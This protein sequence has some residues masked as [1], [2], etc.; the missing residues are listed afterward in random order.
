M[1]RKR[2]TK[3]E[4]AQPLQLPQNK[5]DQVKTRPRGANNISTMS[6]SDLIT[7]QEAAVILNRSVSAFSWANKDGRLEYADHNNRLLNRPGL[8]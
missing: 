5:P 7:Q 2:V 6:F 4:K 1:T 8:E 3:E